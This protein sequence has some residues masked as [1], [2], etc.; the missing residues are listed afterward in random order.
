MPL[1][2][3]SPHRFLAPAPP[4]AQ[5]PKAKPQSG[6]RH[7]A[8]TQTPKHSV[9]ASR[10]R[11]DEADGPRRVTPA[12][13]FVLPPPSSRTP[14]IGEGRRP[15]GQVDDA[16]RTPQATP[17]PKPKFSKVESIDTTSPSSSAN[18]EARNGFDVIQTILFVTEERNKRR[19]VSLEPPTSPTH[20]PSPHRHYSPQIA[21]PISHRFKLPTP[22]ATVFDNT[23]TPAT[24]RQTSSRPHFILPHTSP[25]LTKSA[26]PLPE[27]FSPSRKSGRYMPNGMA[28]TLQ[29]WIHEAA[30]TGYTATT[31]TAVVWG[32]DK[33]D[34]VKMRVR[35]LS[36]MGARGGDEAEVECWPAGVA[37][38]RGATDASL[39]NAS[40]ASSLTQP[41]EDRHG[42]A[43]VKIMLAGQGGAR[44]KGGVRIRVGDIVGVRAPIWDV[45]IGTGE[46]P[47]RW[48]VGVEWVIL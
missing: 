45:R 40:R 3:P 22:R 7:A 39:Y 14:N 17:R 9:F 15:R 6:L 5:K 21:S 37:F 41:E 31:S 32:R 2:T 28:A 26:V 13:R 20:L 10:Q 44:G 1:H 46:Q 4:L 33:E 47:E 19:R 34:G 25:S 12:K 36:V 43:E 42:H 35:V 30:S 48:L 29:S 24:D 27:T 38:V 23:S 11:H 16:F 18:T 8:L